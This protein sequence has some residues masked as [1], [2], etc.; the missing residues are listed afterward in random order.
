MEGIVIIVIAIIAYKIIGDKLAAMAEAS[1]SG[2]FKALLI[3][4]IILVLVL[5]Y[6]YSTLT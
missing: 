5:A 1:W 6:G 2:C 4:G 3:L